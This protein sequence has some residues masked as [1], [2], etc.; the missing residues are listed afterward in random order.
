M[1]G[2]DVCWDSAG[3]GSQ[4]NTPVRD[5]GTFDLKFQFFQLQNRFIIKLYWIHLHSRIKVPEAFQSHIKLSINCWDVEYDIEMEKIKYGLR[6][7][8]T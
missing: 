7:W 8:D 4:V 5:Q 1:V 6:E 2:T 3:P